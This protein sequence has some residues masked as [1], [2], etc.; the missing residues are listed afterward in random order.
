[1]Q[2]PQEL[3]QERNVHITCFYSFFGL[4]NETNITLKSFTST[5]NLYAVDSLT[6]HKLKCRSLVLLISISQLIL[7]LTYN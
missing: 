6:R 2:H 1:M 4:K 3:L 5:P 7:K